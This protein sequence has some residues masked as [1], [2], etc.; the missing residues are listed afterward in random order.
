MGYP[1]EKNEVYD[2]VVTDMT[3][4]GAGVVKINHYPLFVQGALRDE[5][6]RIRV[7]KTLKKY[8]FAQLE[9]VLQPSPI[10]QQA[11]CKVYDTCG[12][13][14]IQHMTYEGQLEEKRKIVENA[15]R[16]LGQ[17]E[18]VVVQPTLGMKD[19]WR[20]RNKSQVPLQYV[21]GRPVW[22]FFKPRTHEIVPTET[23][24][25]QTEEA[26][27]LLNALT[28]SLLELGISL[29]DERR[30]E[31][32]L[33]H[34]IVR[35][36]IQ[37]GEVMVVLVTN[38]TSLPNKELLIDIICQTVPNVTSIV[39]NMN[40]KKTNVIFGPQSKTLYGQSFIVDK[41]GNIAF[42][43]SDRSFYQ[44][45]SEQMEVLYDV[46]LQYAD[47]TGQETVID[48]YCGIGTISLFLAKR[49]KH[50]YGVEIVEQAID[51]AKRNAAYNDIENVTFTAG[52]AEEIVP[53]WYENGVQADVFVVDPPRKGCDVTLLE[54]MIAHEPKKIVYV[55]CNPATLARDVRILVDGGYTLEN[56]QPVDMFG[57]TMHVETVVSLT[58]R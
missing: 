25:I 7:T 1:V 5:T 14:Q 56:V 49:A 8:G 50:V 18:D 46:A 48:A 58:K 11:P 31:G 24:L 35:K 41:I 55:S 29:Y 57:H 39:Q 16:R 51:D 40:T 21:D 19:P 6:V 53:I 22:G 36:G 33:R 12:G 42:E 13:C 32:L 9:E 2:S 30:H 26:D 15:F 43:I 23:C 4:A 28:A 44:V 45:N 3:S 38:G 52:K 54:T 37:T 34:V 20:Y 17:F 47:L 10:R 27:A